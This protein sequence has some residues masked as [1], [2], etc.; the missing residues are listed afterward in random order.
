MNSLVPQ[1]CDLENYPY[2]PID[3]ESFK[4]SSFWIESNDLQKIAYIKLL[5][6]SWYQVPASTLPNDQLLLKHFAST[7]KHSSK[8][9]CLVLNE[10]KGNKVFSRGSDNVSDSKRKYKEA[11]SNKTGLNKVQE[12][13]ILLINTP[14]DIDKNLI[15]HDLLSQ[16]N[17]LCHEYKLASYEATIAARKLRHEGQFIKPLLEKKMD[18]VLEQIDVLIGFSK[19]E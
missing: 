3:V 9:V 2:L 7:A 19:D 8:S 6:T 17:Q 1:E 4:N 13:I 18:D 14:L 10:L 5:L 15:V 11:K 16:F 12:M